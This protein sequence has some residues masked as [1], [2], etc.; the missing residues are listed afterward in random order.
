MAIVTS[1]RCAARSVA[2]AAGVTASFLL[3]PSVLSQTWVNPNTGSW[4]NVGNWIGGV[5]PVAG[6]TN[7]HAGHR[8][9]VHACGRALCQ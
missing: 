7:G 1:R 4:N 9:P 5:I 6:A 3:T 2:W 8:Q